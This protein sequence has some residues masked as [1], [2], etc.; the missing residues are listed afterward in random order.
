MDGSWG[1]RKGFVA[2]SSSSKLGTVAKPYRFI[3]KR[4]IHDMSKELEFLTPHELSF[5]ILLL[6]GNMV[7]VSA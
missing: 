7:Q 3:Q 5:L 1:R 4:R 2:S 6:P